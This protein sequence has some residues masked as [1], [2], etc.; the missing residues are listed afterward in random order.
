MK[1][2]GR[3]KKEE[4]RR[5]NSPHLPFS[6]P[7]PN[8]QSHIQ[9]LK[10]KIPQSPKRKSQI[11]NRYNW[12]PGCAWEPSLRGS[13]SSIESQRRQHHVSKNQHRGRSDRPQYRDN[14]K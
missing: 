3:R 12:F 5:K 9:N 10:S 4:G 14:L 6:P 2:E 11:E 1:E 13:A 7:L 8:P